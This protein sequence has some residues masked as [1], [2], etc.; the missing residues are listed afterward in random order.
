MTAISQLYL[1][2]YFYKKTQGFK[3]TK[4]QGLKIWFD[5]ND[6]STITK[7]GSDLVSQIDDKSGNGNHA[8]QA[9][10]TEQPIWTANILNGMSILRYDG[11][12]DLL[13]VASVSLKMD[14][15]LFFA[16]Q[17]TNASADNIFIEH[18]ANAGAVSGF[19]I[20]GYGNTPMTIK[21][22]VNEFQNSTDTG[23]ASANPMVGVVH[24]EPTHYGYWKEKRRRQIDDHTVPNDSVSATYNLGRREG[25][26]LATNG[27][28]GEL[29]HYERALDHNEIIKVVQYLGDKW[30][31][32][33]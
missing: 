22:D 6:I 7:D 23:W 14:T 15:T 19:H 5:A 27:D 33:V 18:G 11:T 24:I 9:T 2:R 20:N 21:R 28:L 3:P 12:D 26:G 29:I 16:G 4:L 30:G 25:G 32:T 17:F 1:D 13:Q 8:V 10:E 31:V